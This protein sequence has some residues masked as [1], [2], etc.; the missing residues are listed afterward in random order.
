ME[1]SNDKTRELQ[2]EFA[3]IID[4]LTKAKGTHKTAI[5]SLELIRIP[6]F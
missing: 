3:K 4:R 2:T 5:P 1:E 6:P